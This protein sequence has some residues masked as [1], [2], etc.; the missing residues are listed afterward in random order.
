MDYIKIITK[1]LNTERIISSSIV[2][3]KPIGQLFYMM[4]LISPSQEILNQFSTTEMIKSKP[5]EFNAK[6]FM[7]FLQFKNGEISEEEFY[8]NLEN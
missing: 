8:N 4:Q 6:N 2:M 1:E 3:P 7:L 5:E